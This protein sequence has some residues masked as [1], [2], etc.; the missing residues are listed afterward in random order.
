MNKAGHD[1]EEQ[2]DRSGTRQL[3]RDFG[4]HVSG[5]DVTHEKAKLAAYDDIWAIFDERIDSDQINTSEEISANRVQMDARIERL[6][7]SK[8]FKPKHYTPCYWA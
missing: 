4:I 5:S 8:V 7:K 6:T 1:D 2:W 3:M